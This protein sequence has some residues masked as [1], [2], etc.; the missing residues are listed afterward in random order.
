MIETAFII[1]ICSGLLLTIS[2]I[3]PYISK[4]KS[5]GILQLI[6]NEL[7]LKSKPD[8]V[9]TA[10]NDNLDKIVSLLEEIK[11]NQ[12]CSPDTKL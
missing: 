5:N 12:K 6:I 8:T 2:E 9:S 10:N 4:I 3:L 1:S 11:N 7:I